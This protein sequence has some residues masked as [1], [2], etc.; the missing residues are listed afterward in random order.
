MK[1]HALPV[2][3]DGV[4]V[5]VAV[6]LDNLVGLFD[7]GASLWWRNKPTGNITLIKPLRHRVFADFA[8]GQHKPP[9]ALAASCVG[10][11]TIWTIRQNRSATRALDAALLKKDRVNVVARSRIWT[12]T[13]SG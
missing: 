9:P 6:R 1:K 13:Y 11:S 7:G 8:T 3:L 10:E 12:T 2:A 5:K 4:N